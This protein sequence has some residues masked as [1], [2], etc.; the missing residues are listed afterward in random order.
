M[1]NAGNAEFLPR[2]LA[3]EIEF[4]VAI[5]RGIRWKIVGPDRHL[6]PL[7]PLANIPN[8]LL[9]GS[10]SRKVIELPAQFAEPLAANP[11]R[12]GLVRTMAVG[13]REIQGTN[14]AHAQGLAR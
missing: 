1:A 6:T 2:V 8:R 9:A 4:E 7:K 10:P 11:L 3:R 13:A 12:S 5:F 14:L